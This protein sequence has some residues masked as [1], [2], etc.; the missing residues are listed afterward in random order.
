MAA[1]LYSIKPAFQRTLEPLVAGLQRRRVHADTVTWF[2]FG[3]SA[4]AG[5]VALAGQIAPTAL[6]AV[7]PLLLGRMAANAIDGQLARRTTSTT[8]GVVLNEVCDVAGDAVAYLPFAA[9]LGGGS[10]WVVVG[11][12]ASG[13]VAEVAAIA[14]TSGGRRNAGPFGKSDRAL[15]FSLLAVAVAAGVSPSMVAGGLAVAAALGLATIRNR[16][17]SIEVA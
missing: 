10:G 2:G 17:R 16:M 5:A 6:L 12:V 3:L 4:A 7:P 8:R 11:M 1:T 13:L 9:L 15:A 14:G